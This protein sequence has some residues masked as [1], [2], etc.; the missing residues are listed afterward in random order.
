MILNSQIC[1]ALLAYCFQLLFLAHLSQP[2]SA[3]SILGGLGFILLNWRVPPFSKGRSIQNSE[4]TLTK[5]NNLLL[6]NQW[7]NFNQTLHNASLGKGD[8]SL[9]K[10]KAPPLSK[11][12]SCE[13][14]KTHWRNSENALTKFKN[15]LL[16]NHWVNFNQTW[17]N[18]SSGEGDSSLF[19]W[20]A[21]P[22]S[23]GHNSK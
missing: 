9:F 19:K 17:H 4:K 18:A 22:F 11:G 15:L 21:P 20:R 6:Q 1:F 2:N 16:Q 8:S 12:D 5:F 23:K 14:A 10:W 7:P 3:Q 13:I